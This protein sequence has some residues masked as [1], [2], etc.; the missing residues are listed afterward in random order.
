MPLGMLGI[1]MGNTRQL[2]ISGLVT[3]EVFALHRVSIVQN[4]SEKPPQKLLLCS[5]RI[6]EQ[7]R[8]KPGRAATYAGHAWPLQWNP[9]TRIS[10]H[11]T[12]KHCGPYTSERLGTQGRTL[13]SGWSSIPVPQSVTTPPLPHSD[14]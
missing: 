4:S 11:R 8:R 13:S 2:L 12:R 5:K 9:G 1:R 3:A 6:P 7:V 10:Q 14:T